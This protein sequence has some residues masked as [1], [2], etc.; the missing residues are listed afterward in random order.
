MTPNSILFLCVANSARSQMAE[1]LARQMFPCVRIQSAGSRPSQ[2]NPYAIEALAEQGIDATRHVSKSVQDIDPASV[3]LVITLCAEE[4][5]P[6]FL[7]RAEKLHWPIP[8]PA[9]DDPDLTP[10]QLRT[11]FRAGRDEIRHRLERLRAE[12]F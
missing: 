12:R 10:D 7:G 1:G 11:R 5:C 8:D 2:V 3:D 6:L 9:S 4:V